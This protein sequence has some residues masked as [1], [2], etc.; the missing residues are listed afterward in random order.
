MVVLVEELGKY[1]GKIV[2]TP[3]GTPAGK[4]I[5]LD[6]NIRN[7]VTQINVDQASGELAKYP[8]TQLSI[9]N[10]S[11]VILPAW[12]DEAADLER[13]HLTAVKRMGALKSLLADG[14]IDN[15]TYRE[16]TS[17]YESAIHAMESGRIALVESLKERSGKLDQRIRVL[18]LVLTDNKLLYSSGVVEAGTYKEASQTIHEML[19]GNVA[20]KKDIQVT[21]ETLTHLEDQGSSQLSIKPQ[22]TEQK[23]PDFGVVRANEQAPA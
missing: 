8:I 1:L 18:Q 7:E 12:K 2:Q 10:G 23:I 22:Q 19:D 17:E 14:D 5:G 3:Y 20:E 15:S 16:M 4:L 21:I 6:T 11:L 9:Q 13:E